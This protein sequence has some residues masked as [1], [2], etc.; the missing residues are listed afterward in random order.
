MSPVD[1]ELSIV[2]PIY[3]EAGNIPT[4]LARILPILRAETRS[5]EVIFCSDP[6]VHGSAQKITSYDLVSA[7]RIGRMHARKAGMLP[8]SL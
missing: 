5:Y 8:A 1:P 6:S 2:V 7:R 3:N 4:F